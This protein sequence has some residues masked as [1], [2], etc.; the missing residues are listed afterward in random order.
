[1][2][3][4]FWFRLSFCVF[5]LSRARLFVTGF[6]FFFVFF[7]YY[8]IVVWL[9]LLAQSTEWKDSSPILPVMC[10]VRCQTLHT[11]SLTLNM[12]NGYSELSLIN[13]DELL[14]INCDKLLSLS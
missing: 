2:G 12:D 3:C 5:F 1:M 14:L 9:S 6:V 10:L 11:H 4:L 13:C 7:V 8:L